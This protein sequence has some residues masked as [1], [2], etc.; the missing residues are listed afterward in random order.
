MEKEAFIKRIKKEIEKTKTIDGFPFKHSVLYF[1]VDENSNPKSLL[2]Y[3]KCTKNLWVSED[4]TKDLK[5]DI[6]SDKEMFRGMKVIDSEKST[7][8]NNFIYEC[9]SEALGL[10][11]KNCYDVNMKDIVGF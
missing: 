9:F 4:L 3:N 8:I 10:N 2:E 1:S 11:I 7:K 6:Y 5:Q